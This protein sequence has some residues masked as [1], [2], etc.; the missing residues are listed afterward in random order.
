MLTQ[1]G[2][3]T[4]VTYS[5]SESQNCLALGKLQEINGLREDKVSQPDNFKG[6]SLKL[7]QF[8]YFSRYETPFWKDQAPWF[9]RVKSQMC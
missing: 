1:W 4:A 3:F 6:F 7:K 2:Q 9:Y 5:W 8:L